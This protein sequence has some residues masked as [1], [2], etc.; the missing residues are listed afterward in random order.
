MTVISL[1]MAIC[2]SSFDVEF[3]FEFRTSMSASNFAIFSTGVA[4]FAVIN[5]E[6]IQARWHGVSR[7]C[8]SEKKEGCERRKNHEIEN[9]IFGRYVLDFHSFLVQFLSE[10]ESYLV[11][12]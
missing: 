11:N 12:R 6:T 5:Q 2:R 8:A 7:C 9:E 3:R 10:I 1:V 4:M